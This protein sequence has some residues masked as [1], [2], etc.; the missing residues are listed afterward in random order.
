MKRIL[1][2]EDDPFTADVYRNG[3]EWAG[4]TVSC[5][6]SIEDATRQLLHER[7]DALL[8]DLILGEENGIE[9]LRFVR[10]C[11][12]T[13]ETPV[14][15]L[16]N[17]FMPE[18]VREA[19]EAG[20]TEC[21]DKAHASPPRIAVGMRTA[22]DVVHKDHTHTIVAAPA[23]P[24]SKTGA[25]THEADLH[26]SLRG[27]LATRIETTTLH[28]NAWIA[29]NHRVATPEFENLIRSI[30]QVATVAGMAGLT[31]ISQMGSVLEAL[32]AEIQV[33]PSKLTWSSVRTINQ[34][35][36][37]LPKLATSAESQPAGGAWTPLVLTVDDEPVAREFLT[38]ALESAHLNTLNVGDPE[39]ALRM[40]EQ[41]HF[42]LAFL[43]VDM[44]Q[45]NGFELCQRLHDTATNPRT[46][47][48]FVSSMRDEQ[49]RQ[50]FSES[51]AL[52]FINKP[53]MLT[54]V[55]VK[56]LVHLH[57][58]QLARAS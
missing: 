5:A 47:V 22:I 14:I 42:D 55:S 12:S 41:N 9:L 18:R 1:I 11:E 43:D 23:A 50:R 46:P 28:L 15:M 10:S 57:R 8:L 48:V 56:A 39:L 52:D 3:L 38:T 37:L 30:H 31:A 34:A 35:V 13:R 45:M 16:S 36:D 2:V 24:K 54:E 4:F 29:R 40:C 17:A 20:A 21:L 27:V 26:R 7:P 6:A 19:W 51:G 49:T 33:A 32:L 58:S 25:E 53:V 44:P